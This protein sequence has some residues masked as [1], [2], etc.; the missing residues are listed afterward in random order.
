MWESN[1]LIFLFLEL[2]TDANENIIFNSVFW[3]AVLGNL[4][5]SLSMILLPSASSDSWAAY[6]ITVEA[7]P[8]NYNLYRFVR[9]PSIHQIIIDMHKQ[10]WIGWLLKYQNKGSWNAST[11]DQVSYLVQYKWGQQVLEW[12]KWCG[13]KSYGCRMWIMAAE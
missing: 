9:S 13:M 12:R 4:Q 11:Y 1:W 8:C 10:Y 3:P 5:K 6:A 7:Y 2:Y